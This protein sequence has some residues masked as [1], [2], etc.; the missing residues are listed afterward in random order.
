MDTNVQAL[1]NLY[2]QLGGDPA[3][4]ADISTNAGMINAI[5]GLDI[6]GG[7]VDQTYD[8]TSE[9][10]ISGEGVADAIAQTFGN[11][12][13]KYIGKVECTLEMKYFVGSGESFIVVYEGEAPV[14]N[15]PGYDWEKR[16]IV[17]G[18]GFSPTAYSCGPR[19]ITVRKMEYSSSS[20]G[21]T[22][23]RSLYVF[24]LAED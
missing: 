3:D 17:L 7:T 10:P 6:G 24:E 14:T 15:L 13:L 11:G 23:G 9:N 8:P 16:N 21:G 12:S 18:S 5:A 2:V 1:K 22:E 20:A 19:D 4:V